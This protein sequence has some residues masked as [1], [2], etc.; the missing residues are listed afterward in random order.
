MTNSH[1]PNQPIY[2]Q[3]DDWVWRV[4]VPSGPGPHPVILMMHGWTGD[5]NVMWIFASRLPQNA[6]LIAPRGIHPAPGGG[7]GWHAHRSQAWPQVGDFRPSVEQV[8]KLLDQRYFPEADFARLKM[9]G[10][11]Q[12]AALMYTLALLEPQRFQA[13]AGLAGF[14]PEDAG[15]WLAAGVPFRGK[16]VFVAH[17]SRDE[18]VPVEK[19][20]LAVDF[21][22]KAGALVS[23][24][25]DDVGHKL[26]A[27]CFRSLQLFFA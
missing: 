22:E 23:Y 20:R 7:Y 15:A 6:M 12:G 10:F 4:R 13:L 24:C 19:A 27:T 17:G 2:R 11:S 18:T 26:S 21:F 25:E 1:Q 3:F 16:E 9:V 14:L 5:E 8:L